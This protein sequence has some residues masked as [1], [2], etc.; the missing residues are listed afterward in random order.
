MIPK[1]LDDTLG[2][3]VY[4]AGV[5][6]RREL[7][8]ALTTHELTPEQWQVMVAL[9]S[10][11]RPLSQT[12][13]MGLTLKDGPTISRMIRRMDRCGWVKRTKGR[14]DSRCTLIQLTSKGRTAQVELLAAVNSHIWA[15]LR[16]LAREEKETLV[17]LLKRLR[18]VLG[19]LADQPPQPS[20]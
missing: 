5:L 9:G 14:R 3:N 20:R 2:F 15:A 1:A 8:R 12:E 13:I 7:A 16:P 17:R 6:L 11:D 19:D 4:R 18:S 10:T